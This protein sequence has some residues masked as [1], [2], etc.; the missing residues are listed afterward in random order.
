MESAAIQFS[1]VTKKSFFLLVWWAEPFVCFFVCLLVVAVAAV[2]VFPTLLLEGGLV[3]LPAVAADSHLITRAVV[4]LKAL[5]TDP[6]VK[7]VLADTALVGRRVGLVN[8][9]RIARARIRLGFFSGRLVKAVLAQPIALTL[10][11]KVGKELAVGTLAEVLNQVRHWGRR[12]GNQG[13][14]EH[15]DGKGG[16]LE[17][18]G[19]GGVWCLVGAGWAIQF[20][21]PLERLQL[22]FILLKKGVFFLFGG[23]GPLVCFLFLFFILVRYSLL[24]ASGEHVVGDVDVVVAAHLLGVKNLKHVSNGLS[25]VTGS[26]V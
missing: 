9:A 11:Q 7:S 10:V 23:L 25:K 16:H 3:G 21:S 19:A 22:F 2:L 14:L 24:G 18:V 8:H 6:V 26:V 15:V 4:H 1:T 5:N 20:Y 12:Q 17:G 13:G